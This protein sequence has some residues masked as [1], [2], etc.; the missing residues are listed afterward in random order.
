MIRFEN[1]SFGYGSTAT[2][3]NISFHIKKGEFAAIIG[4]NGAGKTTLSKL[5]NGLLKSVSGTV[6]VSGNDTK[7][8]KTSKLAKSV[9]FLFQNPDRQICQNTIRQEIKFG[10]ECVLDDPDE[11]NRR[12]S[13]TLEL[14]DFDGDNDPFSMSRGERQKIAL[15]ALIATR[16]EVLILDEP[17]TGLDY[18]ECMHIMEV[19]RKLN[20]KGTTIIMVSHD[21]ELVSDF[22]K[23]ILVVR[24]GELIGDG[25]TREILADESLLK[26]ASVL[27][28]QI[29]AL[30][31]RLGNDF[32]DVF[33]VDEMCSAIERR[34]R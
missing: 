3:K 31:I 28:P 33:T 16:P 22:A 2:I 14:F 18:R 9:G 11:I 19:M 25:A 4:A 6:T 27:P 8:I 1:V 20:E 12:I 10:L 32:K 15:A 13:E 23:R 5:C 34:C 17:T 26:S 30:A 21:M 24:N 7:K 29:P